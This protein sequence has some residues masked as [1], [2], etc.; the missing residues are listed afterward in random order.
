[1]M[2]ERDFDI[3]LTFTPDGTTTIVNAVICPGRWRIEF[4]VKTSSEDAME[5]EAQ[6]F[7]DAWIQENATKLLAHE[8]N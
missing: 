1:M 4:Y 6:A 2:A 8:N 3:E 5:A 7:L